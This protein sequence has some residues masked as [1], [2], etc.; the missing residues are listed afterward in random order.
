PA[1]QR[2]VVEKLPGRH[3]EVEEMLR[4]SPV[5]PFAVK[6]QDI[7]TGLADYP[8]KRIDLAFVTPGTLDKLARTDVLGRL[9]NSGRTDAQITPLGEPAQATENRGQAHVALPLMDRVLLEGTMQTMWTRNS[10]SLILAGQ[11]DPQFTSHAQYPNRWRL[12]QRDAEGKLQPLPASQPYEAVGY[13]F[14]FTNLA[15]M[16][17]ALLVE[18]HLLFAEPAA[19]FDGANLLRS[20]LPMVLQTKIRAF[21]RDLMRP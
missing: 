5:A 11:L 17:D 8:A 7:P 18:A 3:Q 6:F 9:L 19:W 4:L 20:K 21:R 15:G 1:E 2:Q 16:E 10:H 12:L 14:K 13:Y